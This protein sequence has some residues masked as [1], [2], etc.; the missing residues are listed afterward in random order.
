MGVS[1]IILLKMVNLLKITGGCFEN[2]YIKI[3]H[4]K[5]S[6]PYGQLD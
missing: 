3:L 5:K 4:Q 2:T 6:C 1:E